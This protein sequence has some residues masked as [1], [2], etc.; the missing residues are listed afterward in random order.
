[1]YR[2]PVYAEIMDL[3]APATVPFVVD[4]HLNCW[5]RA[6]NH[7]RYLYLFNPF[8][9]HDLG[10]LMDLRDLFLWQDIG[11]FCLSADSVLKN[12]LVFVRYR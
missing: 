3:L 9:C 11:N 8:F 10:D 1:M 12:K 6:F 2:R 5:F 7:P 4:F